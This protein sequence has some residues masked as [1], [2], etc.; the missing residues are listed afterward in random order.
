MSGEKKH[1]NKFLD[2]LRF[3]NM[4]HWSLCTIL[5]DSKF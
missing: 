4:F 5:C 3:T 1:D 2:M